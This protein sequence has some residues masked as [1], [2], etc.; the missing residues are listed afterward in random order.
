MESMQDEI[1]RTFEDFGLTPFTTLALTDQT[2]P[3][4]TQGRLAL[5]GTEGELASNASVPSEEVNESQ[6]KYVVSFPLGDVPAENL[7][8][9]VKDRVVTIDVKKEEKS[10]DGTCRLYQ[11]YTRKFTLPEHVQAKD[12][13][14]VLT[15]EGVLKLEAPIPQPQLEAPKES[16]NI[17]IQVESVQ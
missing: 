1:E 15:P 4:Q 7:K 10:E 2:R 11:E 16:R 6:D 5:R 3:R 8:I 9:S 17:P 12:V 13:K 14:S